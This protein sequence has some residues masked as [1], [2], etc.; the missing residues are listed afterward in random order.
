[1][2][3]SPCRTSTAF[4]C[5]IRLLLF[6]ILAVEARESNPRIRLLLSQPA[7]LDISV[8]SGP[9]RRRISGINYRG[10]NVELPKGPT[11]RRLSV[12]SLGSLIQEENQDFKSAE[13]LRWQSCAS[14][15]LRDCCSLPN[16]SILLSRD[17]EECRCVAA[18]GV[19]LK[20]SVANRVCSLKWGSCEE[21]TA[22]SCCARAPKAV[23]E[24]YGHL[25]GP[26][27]SNHC[28]CAKAQD[29]KM[30][31][32]GID[33]RCARERLMLRNS[34]TM[35]DWQN[36]KDVLISDCCKLSPKALRIND[37]RGKCRCADA[38][39]EDFPQER[40]D[41]FC[42]LSWGPCQFHTKETCCSMN[43]PAAW[44]KFGNTSASNFSKECACA[45]AEYANTTQEELN[46]QCSARSLLIETERKVQMRR[47]DLRATS[48]GGGCAAGE[49]AFFLNGKKFTAPVSTGFNLRVLS[50]EGAL[51]GWSS[52]QASDDLAE[53]LEDLPI[54][55]LIMLAVDG[56]APVLHARAKTAIKAFGATKI[57]A[58]TIISGG[59]Y[60]LIATKGGKESMEEVSRSN[61]STVLWHVSRKVMSSDGTESLVKA[62]DGRGSELTQL[63]NGVFSSS[64]EPD[65]NCVHMR[66]GD[67]LFFD[68]GTTK[69]L[70][71]VKVALGN[72]K[73]GGPESGKE[74]AC[75]SGLSLA[76]PW[77]Q[78][79]KLNFSNTAKPQEQKLQ[80][81]EAHFLKVRCLANHGSGQ[82][83]VL[84]QMEF[85]GPG[86][87]KKGNSTWLLAKNVTRKTGTAGKDIRQLYKDGKAS[88]K[89][90][91]QKAAESAGKKAGVNSSILKPRAR[92]AVM[93]S[94]PEALAKRQK[95]EDVPFSLGKNVSRDN[96]TTARLDLAESE[97]EADAREERFPSTGWTTTALEA[98]L[99]VNKDLSGSRA[100]SGY[101]A[102][103]VLVCFVW[104]LLNLKDYPYVGDEAQA[105]STQK[106]METVKPPRQRRQKTGDR[107]EGQRAKHRRVDANDK[108]KEQPQRLPAA[109]QDY[110]ELQQMRKVR[111]SE[112]E[113]FE[114][115]RACILIQALVR[116]WKARTR[117]APPARQ[118]VVRLLQESQSIC[119][120]FQ[121]I[122]VANL[123]RDDLNYSLELSCTLDKSQVS[124]VKT[125]EKESRGAVLE[126]PEQLDLRNVHR[127]DNVLD[128]SLW[129]EDEI[130]AAAGLSVEGI[131][132]QFTT[133]NLGDAPDILPLQVPLESTGNRSQWSNA[134][135]ETQ[136]EV[137][138]F[139]ALQFSFR[140]LAAQNLPTVDRLALRDAYV[141]LRVTRADVS[142]LNFL[143]G[144]E[145]C[146]WSGRTPA[147]RDSLNPAWNKVLRCVLPGDPTLKLQVVI[148]DSNAP[149]ADT[150]LGHHVMDLRE[151]ICKPQDL[152]P[153]E[154]RLKFMRLP[155]HAKEPG[156]SSATLTM[157]MASKLLFTK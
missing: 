80:P 142:R 6:Y 52:F 51:L 122:S 37:G 116:G 22:E 18:D 32:L 101:L 17:S 77:K 38:D 62:F 154:H 4:S 29:V 25:G 102:T 86:V 104:I 124:S 144:D 42:E 7:T 16:K 92:K 24:E 128:I 110:K 19:T 46:L 108:Q 120:S 103:I 140:I 97:I 31:Q 95:V 78:R 125:Q 127:K 43:P 1:M 81:F 50:E 28:A 73:F 23:L 67:D 145:N 5:H 155:G 148:W 109:W 113:D 107:S 76:G 12:Q 63:T 68:L 150:P 45:N 91:L 88:T 66:I 105:N 8:P 3:C 47:D 40:I 21:L 152:L 137:L 94:S 151:A 26:A 57:H 85:S 98:A 90:K 15:T 9:T 141:E 53:M 93:R 64:L 49:T 133:F 100:F 58:Y 87:L 84:R 34:K 112:N 79:G 60:A 71:K 56:E 69:F 10:P 89:A 134:V 114:Y 117:I 153:V 70:D 106:I 126:F 30:G 33:K 146:I 65:F 72:A 129:C 44:V 143:R 36:C 74:F 35:K 119:L 2:V 27:L 54:G 99:S 130:I 135:A 136:L 82:A 118:E 83:C 20:Q 14:I 39:P 123:A 59:S 61:A 156:M 139:E 149:L 96:L 55:R 131:L 138:C 157:T 115:E 41:D 13:L 132:R 48:C 11:R 121:G 147:V 75:A 111:K